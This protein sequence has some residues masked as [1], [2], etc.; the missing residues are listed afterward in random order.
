MNAKHPLPLLLPL[1]LAAGALLVSSA[2]VPHPPGSRIPVVA[3]LFRTS[4]RCVG[5]HSGVVSP[6]GEDVSIGYD[7][8][9]S[10]M[11][12][13]ARDPYWQAAVRREVTDH[14]ESSAEI[15]DECAKCH[16][17]MA[18]ATAAAAGTPAAIFAHLGPDADEEQA[19]L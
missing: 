12:N 10:M 13:S 4:D 18:R 17:P 14:P 1:S 3:E 7:W 5:C 6:S 2:A 8:R 15:Q 9:A 19:A 16:M 11:A